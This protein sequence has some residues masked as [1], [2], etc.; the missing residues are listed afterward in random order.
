V[1]GEVDAPQEAAALLLLR[2]VQEELDDPEP[3]YGQVALPVVDRFVPLLPDVISARVGRELLAE[4]EVLLV[5]ADDEHLLVVGSVEDPDLPPIRQPFLVAAQEVLVE[6][7][8]RRDLEALHPHALRVEAGHHVTDRPVLARGVERLQDDED[9]VGVLGRK[10]RLV[11]RK[12]LDPLV[13]QCDPVLLRLDPASNAGSKSLARFTLE[14]G[15]TRNGSMN[16]E[17]RF[18]AW[19]GIFQPSPRVDLA[20]IG[21]S[22]ETVRK[23][24]RSSGRF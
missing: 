16:R 11:I 21:G 12:L 22:A 20:R 5:H 13:Q 17:I 7:G 4:E 1:V 14:P 6:L 18:A 8:R 24:P 9:A 2:Q 15:L 3:V 10:P 23:S 19:S